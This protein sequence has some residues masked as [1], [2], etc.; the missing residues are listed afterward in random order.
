M[1]V[2]SQ[3]RRR[4]RRRRRYALAARLGLVLLALFATA[5]QAFSQSSIWPHPPTWALLTP[6]LTLGAVTAID[7]TRSLYASYRAPLADEARSDV[8]K[9]LVV[10]LVTIGSQLH[11]PVEDLGGNVFVVRSA[12][13]PDRHAPF[14]RR[15]EYLHRYLRFRVT[16]DPQASDI[17]WFRGKGVIGICWAEHRPEHAALAALA[18]RYGH[19]PLSDSQWE[20]VPERSRWGLDRT[21]FVE[22]IGKYAE[23]LAVPIK[24]DDGAFLGCVAVDLKLGRRGARTPT[25]LD[26]PV[27]EG[28]VTTAASVISRR[29]QTGGVL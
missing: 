1:A 15:R 8:Q 22:M 14:W 12:W 27:V 7:N 19:S 20:R 9:A 23:V 26:S 10:A 28:V 2:A 21:E 13:L 16:D 6:A 3:L 4:D 25:V 18:A 29:L 17:D 24:D 5:T 11:L